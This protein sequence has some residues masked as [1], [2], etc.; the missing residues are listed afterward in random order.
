MRKGLINLK[1][2][3]YACGIVYATLLTTHV[4]LFKVIEYRISASILVGFLFV[5]FVGSMG[6]A[7]FKEWGRSILVTFNV[8]LGFYVLMLFS[9]TGDYS[10]LS[11]FFF[12]VSIALFY[13]QK[14][15]YA[16]F[17]HYRKK[18]WKCILIVDDDEVAIK[19]VRPLLI[20]R[21]YSVLSAFSG[22][23]AL[24][25][26]EKQ[27]P[28][29]VLLDVIMPGIKGREVCK[30]IKANEK[31]KDIPVVFLTAKDS[32]DDIK[33]EKEAG[34][35]GHLTKPV[36]PKVLYSLLHEVLD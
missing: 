33:A 20:A 35:S 18:E 28:D 14:N 17:L 23:A 10:W 12:C 19:T 5:L 29:C 1:M 32:E 30:R 31:T 4:Q 2:I 34:A 26:M 3:G 11:Y 22:E 25:I 24:E 6:A 21:G 7:L 27:K 36:N 8:I 13:N 15:I 9:Q 16:R